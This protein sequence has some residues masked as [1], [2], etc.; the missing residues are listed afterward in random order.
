MLPITTEKQD[1]PDWCLYFPL[2]HRLH[3]SFELSLA[4]IL[5]EES[6][7]QVINIYIWP[8]VFVL[9]PRRE[10]KPELIFYCTL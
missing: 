4:D 6:S 10:Q 2:N 5:V 8:V 3:N 1:L 9:A 7:G